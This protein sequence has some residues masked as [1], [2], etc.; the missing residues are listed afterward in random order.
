[1]AVRIGFACRSVVP[2]AAIRIAAPHA[3]IPADLVAELR[4]FAPSRMSNYNALFGATT[5][6]D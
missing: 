2:D 6:I 4:P 1:M 5:T 3:A